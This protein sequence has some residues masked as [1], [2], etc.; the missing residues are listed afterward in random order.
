M[1]WPVARVGDN[2]QAYPSGGSVALVM[3][4]MDRIVGCSR[5]RGGNGEEIRGAAGGNSLSVGD[6]YLPA[7][8]CTN[9]GLV[10]YNFIIAD[11]S[12]EVAKNCAQ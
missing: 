4:S 9:T 1:N 5:N 12:I 10:R 7:F 2:I 8:S 11:L 6:E 3:F